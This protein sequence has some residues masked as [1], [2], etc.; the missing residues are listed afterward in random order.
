MLETIRDYARTLLRQSGEEEHTLCRHADHFCRLVEDGAGAGG[1]SR[2]VEWLLRLDREY[3]NIRAAIGWCVERGEAETGM[4]LA[5]VMLGYLPKRGAVAE[6]RRL[7]TQLL[8]MGEA[9]PRTPVRGR[10]ILAA[11]TLTWLHGEYDAALQLLDEAQ[12]IWEASG[13]PYNAA[14]VRVYRTM[15]LFDNGRIEEALQ[16]GQE[17]ATA[18]RALVERWLTGWAL[19]RLAAVTHQSGE[20]AT[21]RT[22]YEES[23][24]IFRQV[25][26]RHCTALALNGLGEIDRYQ[27]EHSSARACFRESLALLLDLGD[28]HCCAVVLANLAALALAEG[29]LDRARRH[30]EESLVMRWELG[31]TR[32]VAECLEGLARVTLTAA[33]AGA[34]QAARLYAR[35]ASLRHTISARLLPLDR[36]THASDLERLRALLGEDRF[37]AAWTSGW[38]LPVEQEMARRLDAP[39]PS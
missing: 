4:R 2:Q 18:A 35:A 1:S 24:E 10:A 33:G 25:E 5:Q 36:D 27:S 7:L 16:A 29:H 20:E 21:A 30:Y 17:A 38:A 3:P 39:D 14:L 11:W 13:D 28:K 15:T 31:H 32:G 9:A 23:L 37:H 8:Q 34:A 22:Q 19:L 26:D 12:S 6:G